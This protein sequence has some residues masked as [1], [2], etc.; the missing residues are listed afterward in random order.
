MNKDQT[1]GRVKE[2]KGK[3]KEVVGHLVVTGNYRA[4]LARRAD[5]AKASETGCRRRVVSRLGA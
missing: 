2:A 5:C 3:V 4:L 1:G